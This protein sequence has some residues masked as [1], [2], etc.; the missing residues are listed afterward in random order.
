MIYGYFDA[1]G[2][3]YIEAHISIERLEVD[4]YV[5][6]LVDTGAYSGA[7]HPADGKFL[8]CRF[9]LLTDPHEVDGVGGSQEYYEEEATIT[10]EAEDGSSYG[11]VVDL[12]V[13]KPSPDID[14]LPS[15]LGR[16]LINDMRVTYHRA[17]ELLQ[18]EPPR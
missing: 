1:Y 15:L 14:D 2:T 13:A 5:Q 9:D 18:F 16:D 12:D 17:I 3:P 10:F 7:L 8:G 4:G 11:F 6:F